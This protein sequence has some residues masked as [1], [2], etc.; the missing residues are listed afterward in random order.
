MIG[1]RAALVVDNQIAV[2]AFG[3]EIDDRSLDTPIGKCDFQW[4][5]YVKLR[6]SATPYRTLIG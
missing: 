2:F 6:I 5:F 4:L 3:Q 1:H